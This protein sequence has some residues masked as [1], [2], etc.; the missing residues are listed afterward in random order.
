MSLSRWLG[1]KVE[2][3]HKNL[4]IHLGLSHERLIEQIGE[5]QGSVRHPGRA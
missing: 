4:W 1:R 2:E 5:M 3:S